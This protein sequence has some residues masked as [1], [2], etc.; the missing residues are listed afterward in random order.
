MDRILNDWCIPS[1]GPRARESLLSGRESRLHRPPIHSAIPLSRGSDKNASPP[2]TSSARFHSLI[3][4]LSLWPRTDDTPRAHKYTHTR[5]SRSRGTWSFC[6]LVFHVECVSGCGAVGTCPPRPKGKGD[7][8]LSLSP[9][10]SLGSSRSLLPP[11]FP[12]SPISS[13]AGAYVR[14]NVY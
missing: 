7:L 5:S 12:F 6:L 9:R 4:P 14:Y 11:S 8:S 13:S 2:S 1:S 3:P 10:L